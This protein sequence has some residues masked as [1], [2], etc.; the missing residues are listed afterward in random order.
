MIA[1]LLALALLPAVFWDKGPETAAQLKQAGIQQ[2]YV[3]ASQDVSAWTST[4][5]KAVALDDA[6]Q[7]KWTKIPKPGVRYRM[8]Q[9]GPTQVPWVDANGWRFERGVTRADYADLPAG[10]AAIAAA[11]AHMYNAEAILHAQADDM[12][13]L[14]AMMKFL[15][16]VPDRL[17]PVRTNIGVVDDGTPLLG[18]VLNLLTRRNLLYHVVKTPQPQDAVTVQLDTPDFPRDSARDPYKFV[19]VVRNKVTDP[20]RVLR[21]YNT[22]VTVGR[23]TGN[24]E[25]ARLCLL[26]Y[27]TMPVQDVRI[28]VLSRYKEGALQLSD[29]G[30]TPMADYYLDSDA[31]EF[32]IPLLARYAVIDLE[33][34]P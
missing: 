11:E 7:Q 16:T 21:I 22:S 29:R 10:S 3:P 23:L 8:S 6:T 17:L 1:P 20:K 2:V 28:R 18:E 14:G 9:A 34:V 5:L 13:A 25:R 24:G 33:R 26:N 4:G 15:K 31:T 27:T 32:T 12:T 30:N 19:E